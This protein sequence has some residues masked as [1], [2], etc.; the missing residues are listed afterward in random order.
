MEQSTRK[1]SCFAILCLSK[2]F[3]HCQAIL[4]IDHEHFPAHGNDAAGRFTLGTTLSSWPFPQY[5][6]T[7]MPTY[8]QKTS[9]KAEARGFCFGESGSCFLFWMLNFLPLLYQG[10]FTSCWL[11][12]SYTSSA[13]D[14]F[15][16]TSEQRQHKFKIVYVFHSA[17]V[18][19]QCDWSNIC[20]PQTR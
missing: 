15:L 18:S 13:K 12:P 17:K 14:T 8:M 20:F 19:I 10:H 4:E 9:V 3:S 16:T 5:T 2:C 6:Y 1:F 11:D 7:L